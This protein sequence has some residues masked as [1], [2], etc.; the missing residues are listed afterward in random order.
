MI[1]FYKASKR[2]GIKLKPNKW[3][4]GF[5]G[6][7]WHLTEKELRALALP[8]VKALDDGMDA[9]RAKELAEQRVKDASAAKA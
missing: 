8:I 2:I 3:L 6:N 1:E 9:Q 5:G 7:R 4:F